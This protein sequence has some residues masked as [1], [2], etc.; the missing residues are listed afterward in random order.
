MAERKPRAKTGEAILAERCTPE[1]IHNLK[2]FLKS[3][4][5][6]KHRDEVL[7]FEA[8]LGYIDGERVRDIAERAKGT[9][10]MVN[11]WLR[12]YAVGGAE[13]L[14]TQPR[15]GA[16]GKLTDEQRAELTRLI[17]AGPAAAGY[18]S[19]V[20]TGPM[21]ADLVLKRFDVRFHHQYIP[22][23]LA[24]LDFSV[25]RPRKRLARADADA[26]RDWAESRFPEI[27]KKPMSAVASSSSK[28]R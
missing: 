16:P 23:L 2:D 8:V 6:K 9:R 12:W 20:W 13:A 4:K 28:T 27:K 18:T 25:Q 15:T 14:L 17:E 19:G 3:A 24:K 21:V 1:D 5:R 26:Q 10:S 11:K 22:R 7:R